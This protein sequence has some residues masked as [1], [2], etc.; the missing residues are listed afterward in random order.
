MAFARYEGEFLREISM[1]VGGIG[2]GC[3]GLGGNG[4]LVDWEIDGPG[5]GRMNPFT[6]F[7]VK[8]EYSKGVAARVLQGD[9]QR[10]LSGSYT[11]CVHGHN[12]F[13]YGPDSGTMAG[14]PHFE[15]C[16][17]EGA[18]PWAKV[19]FSGGN[20]PGKPG[21]SAFSSFIPLNSEDSSLP[22]AFYRVEME[23][24]TDEEITYTAA[25]TMGNFMGKGVNRRFSEGGY[26]G[27]EIDGG[28]NSLCVV[29][30]GGDVSVQE[31]W[32][33]G[34]WFDS[35][36][37]YWEQFAGA[38]FMPERSYGDEGNDRG[39]VEARFTLRPGEKGG[40]NFVMAWRLPWEVDDW[41]A[42]GARWTRYYAT[43]FES[44]RAAAMY[45]MKKR[46]TLEKKTMEFRDAMY[47]CDMPRKLIEA[48]GASLSILVTPECLRLEDSS[49]FAW[50]GL[51]EKGGSCE[52]TCQHVWNY[53]YALPY[54]F[55]DLEMSVRR[56]ERD[57]S[58]W[59][60][61]HISFR[62]KLPAGSGK[63]WVMPCV[64]GQMGY[65]MKVYR[66]WKFSGDDRWLREM[67]P[68]ARRALEFAWQDGP[69][70]W[71]AD[72]DGVL[73]G[74][75]HHTLDMELFGPSSWLEGFYLMALKAC[76]EMAEYL[77]EDAAEY[78]RLFESG[79]KYL[80]EELFNGSY[81][82]Q[83]VDL[84]D[85]SILDKFAAA[86]NGWG[87]LTGG[88]VYKYWNEEAGEM[89]YQIAGGLIIDQA[90]AQWHANLI[91]LGEIYEKDKLRTA[92]FSL[93]RH[94]FKENFRDF[95]NPCRVFSLNGEGGTVMCEY[96]EGAV[97]P[98]I[99][100][101]YCQETM[102]GFEYAAAALMLQ[103]GLTDKG[104]R[105]IEAVRD[106]YDG[107]KRNPYNEIECGSNYSRTMAAFS[108]IP[109]WAGFEC[110]AVKKHMGF[111]PVYECKKTMWFMG[112]AW[113]EA[114]LSDINTKIS[115]K[116]GKLELKSLGLPAWPRMIKVDG[117]E[118]KFT[119]GRRIEFA[120]TVT[121]VQSIEIFG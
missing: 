3:I 94:N 96:P 117:R 72:R 5:K 84:K 101:P 99:S 9:W 17:F 77:G 83:K 70:K 12:G 4:A 103:E 88:D 16:A 40:V 1:P 61:G 19:E 35:A 37:V 81:Y 13:G 108:F 41:D 14:F 64:D 8:A 23:N 38:G 2:A 15:N 6:H 55:P 80:N 21:L 95:C 107:K 104:V 57:H 50:E 121:A 46:G 39:T 118:V 67:W 49:F 114:E 58:Q 92:L 78:L 86:E 10:D 71:D 116:S 31:C 65:I 33:R 51:N 53:A 43:R 74:R 62:L 98:V 75:Q 44:A 30:D 20:F 115:V 110:D 68:S 52:G 22:C 45:A 34:G 97:K 25:F 102:T 24:D 11:G 63:G 7:A 111:L 54:L 119:C 56:L 60:D 42:D 76:A 90:L 100:V 93:Y 87:V 85:K 91:G 29:T 18:F 59:E 73:E 113:G 26:T 105:M 32:Y 66:E 89:K 120:E 82:D 69:V 47:T 28:E 48:A 106:R 112:G 27:L 109:V 36:T 79:K